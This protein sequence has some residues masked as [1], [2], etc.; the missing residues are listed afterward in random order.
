MNFYAQQQISTNQTTILTFDHHYFNCQYFDNHYFDC[1]ATRTHLLEVV[2][3]A[4]ILFTVQFITLHNKLSSAVY[5]YRSCLCACLQR[6]GGVCLYVCLWVCYYDNSKLHASILTKLGLW[7]KVVTIS[8]W[9]NFGH[10]APQGRGSATGVK[11]FGSVLLQPVN[12]VCV[13]LSAFFIV[14]CS[15]YWKTVNN[16]NITSTPLSPLRQSLLWFFPS[17]AITISVF[18]HVHGSKI[19]LQLL[20]PTPRS[21]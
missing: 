19:F 4:C 21:P 17:Q 10:P 2:E 7:V 8:S 18:N 13:S 1:H 14:L 15:I 12:S 6:A 11:I 9:L 20:Q 3:L 16:S 5:C